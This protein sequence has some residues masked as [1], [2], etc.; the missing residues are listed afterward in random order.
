MNSAFDHSHS[1]LSRLL[2]ELD[3]HVDALRHRSG[4]VESLLE[5]FSWYAREFGD[6]LREHMGEE[7]GSI[8]PSVRQRLNDNDAPRIDQLINEHRD[9]LTLVEELWAE[10]ENSAS[11][12]CIDASIK[13]LDDCVRVLRY[14]FYA[15]TNHERMVFEKASIAEEGAADKADSADE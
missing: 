2:D 8:F 7:E 13:R 10:L 1:D 3:S 6:E 9:L 11:A 5:A 14:A 15:H 4:D 12:D